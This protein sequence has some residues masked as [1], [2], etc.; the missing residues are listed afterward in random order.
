MA[1]YSEED[2]KKA[3]EAALK[4]MLE[5]GD[6]FVVAAKL[7]SRFNKDI[8]EI[9]P[10]AKVFKDFL[11]GATTELEDMGVAAKKFDAAIKKAS[12][13][14][15]KNTSVVKKGLLEEEKART[16]NKI[17]IHNS[18]IAS[19]N[20]AIGLGGVAKTMLS[21]ATDFVKGLQTNQ[22][23]TELAGKSALKAAESIGKVAD[24][25]ASFVSTIGFLLA[26]LP[27]GRIIKGIGYGLT[28]LGLGVEAL[29]PALTEAATEGV[30]I[31]N[32][33][34]ERTK[35]SFRDITSTGAEFAGGMTELRKISAEAGLDIEQ[36]ATIT[37]SSNE[38][39]SNMGL[40]IAESIKRFAGI[41]K[42]LRN[43]PLGIQLRKLGLSAEEQG[44][45]A[46]LTASMLNA[47]GRL[48]S[49]SDK[50]VAAATVQYT[51]DLKV[52]Q[53]ITGE[54]AKKQLEAARKASL[55]ASVMSAAAEIDPEK[56]M[57]KVIDSMARVPEFLRTGVLEKI[58]LNAIVDPATNILM[59]QVPKVGE[60]VN[61]YQNLLNDTTI[62]SAEMVKQVDILVEEIAVYARKNPQLMREI[63]VANLALK[64]NI[65]D[66]AG[67]ADMFN[68]LID[69]GT[70]QGEGTVEATRNAVEAAAKNQ[71][72]LDRSV[73][74][75]DEGTQKLKAQF[76]TALT[77]PLTVYTGVLATGTNAV[78][79]FTDQI[80]KATEAAGGSTTES[81]SS[82]TST[83]TP[84]FFERLYEST[85]TSKTRKERQ[86]M[87]SSS[88]VSG[89][90]GEPFSPG[91]A[92]GGISTGPLS[93]YQEVLHGT[94]AVVPLPDNRSIPVTLTNSQSNNST[95]DTKEMV[96]A[97]NQQTGLLNRILVSMEKNNQLTSGILQ[98]S[99]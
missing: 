23:G 59:A 10:T 78:K 32:T 41:N 33:E 43:S 91:F 19:T 31:L 89:V 22:E 74:A 6:A 14:S 97:I 3:T 18:K 70:K 25:A 53:N 64:G 40:G 98:T 92:Q 57:Q 37:K 72:A 88:A 86:S 58:A 93:G 26:L 66:A 44:E 69:R 24:V 20:F 76:G 84:G 60:F 8:K 46:T 81:K 85:F 94:E 30:K 75:I 96:S 63:D 39:L 79:E 7:V 99:Y 73:A 52:L 12:E 1:E 28:V 45:M 38:N 80:N 16:L 2:V 47:S 61:R 83:G 13:S 82:Q 67:S 77:G 95:M 62:S 9:Q 29:G 65:G 15:D 55:R 21:G 87:N 27:A 36:L 51:K 4:S 49:M 90:T 50:E 71:E 42:E 11:K 48:R 56:G 34:L 54:D 5:G 68:Q 17:A 35:K